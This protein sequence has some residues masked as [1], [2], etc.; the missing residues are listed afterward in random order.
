MPMEMRGRI[1]MDCAQGVRFC[2]GAVD[3]LFHTAGASGLSLKGSMQRA[4]RNLHAINMH[5]LL[6]YDTS[7]ELYGRVML[8]LEPNTEII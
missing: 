2:M 7:A 8:G 4:W 1:R 3:K 6:A 5:G